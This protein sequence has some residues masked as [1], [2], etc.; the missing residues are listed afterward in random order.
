MEDSDRRLDWLVLFI[1]LFSFSI[2]LARTFDLVIIRG[3]YFSHL[4]EENRLREIKLPAVRGK[5]LARDGQ[6]LAEDRVAY[7]NLGGE[8]IEKEAALKLLAE[9]KKI[10]RRFLRFY[11][12]GSMTAHL[13]GYLGKAGPEEVGSRNCGH[14]GKKGRPIQADDWLGR[15]GLEQ[16]YDCLLRGTAGKLL[17]EL[18]T[19]GRVVRELGKIP[20]LPGRDITTNIDIGLQ[21]V[22]WEAI[23]NYKGA[24][25]VLN[26]QSGAVLSLVSSPS[27]DPNY[28]T[29]QFDEG[30][31]KQYLT[32]KERMVFLNRAISGAYHPGSVF[33]P[34]VAIAALEERKIDPS[35]KIEDVGVIKIGQWQ[36]AN[37]Y[38]TEYGRK[39]G[40]VDLV[41]AIR[42]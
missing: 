19:F 40:M 5:I 9:G 39:E 31:V 38:W 32:D 4:S 21:K 34:L 23:Q 3:S 11:P 42:L 2:L 7:A 29:W 27:F 8:V 41:K 24:V 26:P 22:V 16:Q 17:V 13:T 25:V 18:D 28:F 14:G 35:T 33:K 37:W 1:C 10:E 15:G 30:K 20:P 36:F 12:F 6:A